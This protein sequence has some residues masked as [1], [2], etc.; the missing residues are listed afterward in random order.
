K[1]NITPDGFIDIV[2]R[3][4]CNVAVTRLRLDSKKPAD[5]QLDRYL[6]DFI[7]TD[8]FNIME[9]AMGNSSNPTQQHCETSVQ[10]VLLGKNTVTCH[11]EGIFSHRLIR[12]YDGVVEKQIVDK[13]FEPQGRIS[14][15]CV[16]PCGK[17][18]FTTTILN[19]RDSRAFGPKFVEE[20]KCEMHAILDDEPSLENLA[21]RTIVKNL[22]HS[23]D[24]S[25]CQL[26]HNCPGLVKKILTSN[27]K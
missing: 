22:S 13:I 20:W 10:S 8:A 16:S 9:Y 25:F 5:Q 27:N 21:R 24:E 1:I 2:S 23:Q 12:R 14:S 11:P 4:L 3:D 6:M 19:E 7:F 15:M 18:M 17:F 26:L